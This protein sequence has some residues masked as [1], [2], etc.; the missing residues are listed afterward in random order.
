[1]PSLYT[2]LVQLLKEHRND[3]ISKR[4]YPIKAV[5]LPLWGVWGWE[6]QVFDTAH[7]LLTQQASLSGWDPAW[8]LAGCQLTLADA[9][10]Y[11]RVT[12]N[13]DEYEL[14]IVVKQGLWRVG[15]RTRVVKR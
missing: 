6:R 13:P 9:Q 2:D 5:R 10:A 14:L 11:Q 15:L 7:R 12:S 1:M 3:W 4:D 8:R